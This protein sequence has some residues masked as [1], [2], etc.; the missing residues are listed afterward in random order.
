MWRVFLDL[1]Q[2]YFQELF[3]Q[4][5]GATFY[6]RKLALSSVCIWLYF[7]CTDL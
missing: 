7:I 6:F 4:H 3:V 1:I 2:M 5:G